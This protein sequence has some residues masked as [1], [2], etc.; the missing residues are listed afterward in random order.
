MGH[1]SREDGAFTGDGLYMVNFSNQLMVKIL[2]LTPYGMLKI[3]SVNPDFK[4]TR[5]I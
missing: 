1:F 2:Q 5:S 4:A 3:V